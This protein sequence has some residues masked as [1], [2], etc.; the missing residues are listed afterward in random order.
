M[1]FLER[2]EHELAFSLRFFFCLLLNDFMV[3]HV[4]VTG[5]ISAADLSLRS[6]TMA[7][8]LCKFEFESVFCCSHSRSYS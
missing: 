1:M 2:L 6:L 5:V 4:V 3:F 7:T 8:S